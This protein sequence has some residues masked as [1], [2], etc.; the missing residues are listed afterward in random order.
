MQFG[1]SC[2][3]QEIHSQYLDKIEGFFFPPTWNRPFR[4]RINKQTNCWLQ[5]GS[6]CFCGK[7]GMR[8]WDL[9]VIVREWAALRTGKATLA[10]LLLH[11]CYCS[12]IS[13]ADGRFVSARVFVFVLWMN[14]AV[15]FLVLFSLLLT[16]VCLRNLTK[17]VLASHWTSACRNH[18]IYPH[19][20][21]IYDIYLEEAMSFF[22]DFTNLNSISCHIKFRI[23]VSMRA[24]Q[25]RFWPISEILFCNS[26]WVAETRD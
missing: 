19:S 6:G 7:C 2:C 14:A 22:Y 3:W 10:Q 17:A 15:F 5:F 11:K 8:I 16:S 1:I 9:T 23:A 20:S 18:F 21:A 26:A 13:L 25:K 24:L 4:A 12:C